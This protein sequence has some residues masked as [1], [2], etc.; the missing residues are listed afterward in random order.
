[1]SSAAEG[2][3]QVRNAVSRGNSAVFETKSQV[4]SNFISLSDGS[5]ER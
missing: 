2:Q 1:M 3:F 5:P 4:K